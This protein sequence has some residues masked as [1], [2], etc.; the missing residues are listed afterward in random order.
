MDAC[1][2]SGCAGASGNEIGGSHART[3]VDPKESS[4]LGIPE[5]GVR[6][7]QASGSNSSNNGYYMRVEL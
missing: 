5:S 6:M 4:C 1:V 2:L 7:R 3:R